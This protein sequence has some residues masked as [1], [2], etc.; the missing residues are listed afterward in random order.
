MSNENDLWLFDQNDFKD[1]VT[2]LLLKD[3]RETS[4]DD[5]ELKK[6][7]SMQFINES[8]MKLWTT[9]LFDKVCLSWGRSFSASD[10]F[11]RSQRSCQSVYQNNQFI[12]QSQLKISKKKWNITG[13]IYLEN[14]FTILFTTMQQYL[15]EKVEKMPV[16]ISI[17]Y[18]RGKK[19]RHS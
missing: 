17:M 8:E 16:I 5:L 2:L 13:V 4:E 15:L 11:F 6:L 3:K 12:F 10:R 14:M 1:A 19:Y 18:S 7:I 9:D